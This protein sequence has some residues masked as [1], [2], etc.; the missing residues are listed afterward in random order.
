MEAKTVMRTKTTALATILLLASILGVAALADDDED[1][2]RITIES[3]GKGDCPHVL[4][5]GAGGEV[6]SLGSYA[7]LGVQLTSLTP[8]LRRH[9]G[10]PEDAGVMI[11]G[12]EEGSPAEAAGLR[13]GDIVTRFDGEDVASGGR[14]ARLVRKHEK[15]DTV[16]LE[17]WRGG[18]V[19]TMT[20]TLDERRRC[21]L[22]IS[23][24]IDLEELPRVDLKEL[25]ID[26]ENLPRFEHLLELHEFDGEAME[27]AME[28]MREA[29][30]HQDWESHLERLEEVDMTGI[31]E[32]LHE[33]MER[34]HELEDEI[35][36]E[37]ERVETDG[38]RVE[39]DGG[40]GSEIY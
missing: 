24:M 10:V 8:E 13:V 26:L 31:E 25:S 21:G 7:F 33:A 16:T 20:V 6:M 17:L 18:K 1:K 22:D 23:H 28:R 5:V 11:G 4:R 9:F 34:L 19:S 29:L 14:L 38:D 3:L 35:R 30:S 40:G 27:E 37:K 15:D 39:T 2:R 32:R 36:S 12:V